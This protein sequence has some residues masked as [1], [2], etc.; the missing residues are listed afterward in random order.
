M[1]ENNKSSNRRSFVRK[2]LGLGAAAGA[3]SLLLAGDK[4]LIPLAQAGSGK[5]WLTMAAIIY[6]QIPNK[7]N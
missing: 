6:T 5:P 2:L 4:N 7:G 3:T 1:E